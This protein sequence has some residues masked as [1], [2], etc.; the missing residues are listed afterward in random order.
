[1]QRID[2]HVGAYIYTEGQE[3]LRLYQFISI[4]KVD[5]ACYGLAHGLAQLGKKGVS[6]SIR[7]SV[8]ASLASLATEVCN[9][10]DEPL[11]A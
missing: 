11:V 9:W 4:C 6:G 7:D 1:M 8:P 3:L 2:P 10:V 5:R